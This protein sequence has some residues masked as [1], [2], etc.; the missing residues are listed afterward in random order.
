[1]SENDNLRETP[2]GGRKGGTRFPQVS[3]K[4]AV[5]YARKLVSK[6]HTGPQPASIIL[7]GVFDAKGGMG[8]VRAGALK[9]YGLLEGPAD[10]YTASELARTL[11][12]AP[13]DELQSYVRTALLRAN[14]YR[15]LYDT[16]VGDTVTK[17]KIGQ[18]ASALKVHPES[19]A[20][21][22]QL[23]V[24]G[25]EYAGLAKIDGDNVTILRSDAPA[26]VAQNS[27]SAESEDAVEEYEGDGHAEAEPDERPDAD[28]EDQHPPRAKGP[29][30]A[31]ATVAIKVDPSTHTDD[32]EKQLKL[33]RKFGVI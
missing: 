17:A 24:E 25:A 30:R 32:L 20:M 21:A 3:L 23:F 1:M 6:T 19:V 29:V 8:Q 7:K 4:K 11:V 28:D 9:Q 22:T 31:V 18:Q 16:F 15:S 2:K 12:A 10:A 27:P 13:P 26:A 5:E 14:V 33:L